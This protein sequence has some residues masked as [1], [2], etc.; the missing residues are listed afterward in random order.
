MTAEKCNDVNI[1]ITVDN[2]AQNESILRHCGQE[3]EIGEVL[4]PMQK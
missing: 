1:M 3:A 4:L 2:F